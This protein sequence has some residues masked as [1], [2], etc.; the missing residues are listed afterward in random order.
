MAGGEGFGNQPAAGRRGD[1]PGL[2]QC[3]LAQRAAAQE[4]ALG[5]FAIPERGGGSGNGRVGRSGR[6]GGG[7]DRDGLGALDPGMVG[8][9]DHGRDLAGIVLGHG[10][11]LGP[12]LGQVAFRSGGA[13]PVRHRPGDPFGIR[14]QRGVEMLVVGGVI[15]DHVDDRAAGLAGIVEVGK[16]VAQA[17]AEVQQGNRRLVRH[18]AI[19][20]GRAGHHAFEQ[21]QDRAHPVL[22]VNRGNQ[23]HFRRAGVGETDLHAA[24]MQGL[25]K[26]FRTIHFSQSSLATC[27]S[28]AATR[29]NRIQPR[30]RR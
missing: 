8:W 30:S 17:R 27:G 15:A 21:P 28:A 9:H 5:P 18:P 3:F 19:T 11:G 23:L 13:D 10:K 20:I 14:S 29:C 6:R 26:G 7:G 24:G 25:D 1:P 2:D 4:Q 16:P 22:P 12:G